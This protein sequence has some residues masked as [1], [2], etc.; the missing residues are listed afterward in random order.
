MCGCMTPRRRAGLVKASRQGPG[1]GCLLAAAQL[2]GC[3]HVLS[4]MGAASG[5][6]PLASQSVNPHQASCMQRGAGGAPGAR[7][8]WLLLFSTFICWHLVAPAAAAR[9]AARPP[10]WLLCMGSRPFPRALRE[11]LWLILGLQLASTAR[12]RVQHAPAT[13][14]CIEG[15]S[16]PPPQRHNLQPMGKKELL[17][18]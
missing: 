4:G 13:I 8:A 12:L 7:R 16:G 5:N 17:F 15:A 18:N 1:L 9:A 3:L 2:A 10:V 6:V 14:T 11:L